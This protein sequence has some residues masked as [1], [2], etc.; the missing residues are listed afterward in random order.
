MVIYMTR[1]CVFCGGTELSNEH[2]FAKWLLKELQVE[3]SNL[4]AVHT[5]FFGAT[6]SIRKM[7]YKNLVNGSVCKNCN[8]GWM[9]KLELDCK[10]H[11]TNLI[12]LN[13][14]E[15]E[16]QWMQNN[17]N[18]LAQWVFKNA[19]LLN[20]AS[21]YH[22]IVPHQHFKQLYNREIPKNVFIS[23]CIIDEKDKGL[24][25]IQSIGFAFLYDKRIDM[26]KKEKVIILLSQ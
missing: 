6:K 1:E 18:I 24:E 11:L 15:E 7:R 22:K 8:N 14:F 2:I 17:N 3:S 4:N 20:H 9:S 12:N 5:N 13:N 23:F 19:I 10:N 25:W 21:N 16:F 26:S